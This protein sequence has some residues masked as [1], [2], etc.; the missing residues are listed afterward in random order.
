MEMQPKALIVEDD[1]AT[2]SLLRE[3]VVAQGCQAEIVT[4]GETA[5]QRLRANDYDVVLLDIILPR[6]SGIEVMDIVAEQKPHLLERIIVVTGVNL[7]DIR[8]LFPTVCHVLGK[9][10]LPSRLLQ[11]IRTCLV[12]ARPPRSDAQFTQG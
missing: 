3:L 6:V 8:K 1:R 7:D 11:T 10:V 2:A 5:V 4:D 12:T 9:P